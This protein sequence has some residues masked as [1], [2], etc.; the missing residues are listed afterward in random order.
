M[1]LL[2]GAQQRRIQE[3]EMQLASD[4]QPMQLLYFVVCVSKEGEEKG[5]NIDETILMEENGKEILSMHRQNS[6]KPLQPLR[7]IACVV[8][9]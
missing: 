1:N 6:W 3:C 8:P 7:S 9:V 5:K 4:L 2:D